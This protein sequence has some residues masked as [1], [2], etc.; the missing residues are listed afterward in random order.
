MSYFSAQDCSTPANV[1]FA[2]SDTKLSENDYMRVIEFLTSL[3]DRMEVSEKNKQVGFVQVTNLGTTKV[4]MSGQSNGEM[5]NTLQRLTRQNGE[6]DINGY[7]GLFREISEMFDMG[8]Q[9]IDNVIVMISSNGKD[10]IRELA[11]A[12]K[13]TFTIG[14]MVGAVQKR[15]D[16]YF[17]A[18]SYKDLQ[19]L[20]RDVH[21]AICNSKYWIVKQNDPWLPDM[22]AA[23][24]NTFECFLANYQNISKE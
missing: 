24:N 13:R 8:R 7:D 19:S 2:L 18:S 9:D 5:K 4:D 15:D 12:G 23:S 16:E 14:I 3:V 1:V 17:T 20:T 6:L 10:N 21:A 22:N 11:L